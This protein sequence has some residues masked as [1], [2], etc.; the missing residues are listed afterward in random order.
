MIT[1]YYFKE[2]NP[3]KKVDLAKLETELHKK[4]IN[5]G[6]KLLSEITKIRKIEFPKNIEK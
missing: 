5:N 6:I 2:K 1:T 4:D 3:Y